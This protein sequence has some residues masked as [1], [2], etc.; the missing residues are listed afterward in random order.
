MRHLVALLATLVFASNV[1]AQIDVPKELQGK[2]ISVVVPW[3]AGGQSDVWNRITGARV[4]DLTGLDIVIVNKPGAD[5]Q[6]GVAEVAKSAPDGTTILG[7]D[8]GFILSPMFKDVNA[9][10]RSKLVTVLASYRTAQGFYVRS[11]SKYQN[12][13]DL[14]NDV[15]TNPG[16]LNI[17]SHYPLAK[18]ITDRVIGEINGQVQYINYKGGP[19][20]VT[21]LIGGH[22]DVIVAP[23]I[24]LSHV[25]SGKIR[26]LAFSSSDRLAE[27]PTV[28]L[29]RETIPGFSF[30]NF[31]GVYAPAGTPKHIV[32]FYN[33]VYREAFK[34]QSAQDFLKSTSA[35]LFDGSPAEAEKFV[36]AN[37]NFWRPIVA[38]YHK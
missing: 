22:V 6:I 18:V 10:P 21:D 37:E 2:T 36:Q 35:R 38:K 15:K 32:E 9:V 28:G 19:Q 24:V 13:K 27:F 8:S 16:K 30:E 4:K 33:R 1:M 7:T 17:G 12:L 34:D 3:A 11:D 25:R 26:A 5:G 20:A 29:I 23:P 14:F 31:A